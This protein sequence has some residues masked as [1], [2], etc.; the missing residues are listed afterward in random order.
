[1]RG[2]TME[3]KSVA[4]F[5][6][7][8][9]VGKSTISAELSGSL[10]EI[11]SNYK[12]KFNIES[13]V[14]L[15]AVDD[16]LDSLSFV[17]TDINTIGSGL[18]EYLL[19]PSESATTNFIVSDVKPLLDVSHIQSLMGTNA[20]LSELIEKIK[21]TGSDYNAAF[22]TVQEHILSRLDSLKNQ[23]DE[24][25][26]DMPPGNSTL[27][28]MLLAWVNEIMIVTTTETPSVRNSSKVFATLRDN[29]IS[30]DKIKY[31]VINKH[32]N[33][34]DTRSVLDILI[35]TYS[36]MNI[37]IFGPIPETVKISR[38][39]KYGKNIKELDIVTH[40]TYIWP[41]CQEVISR[42]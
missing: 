20:S 31:L 38:P 24:I 33:N 15:I 34:N 7:K 19:A 29:N 26:L 2:V 28:L 35:N 21:K 14:L 17:G 18:E 37:K 3:C 10:A 22:Q 25:I 27:S 39:H 42:A 36:S 13:R 8:G 1:M 12:E 41:I 16:Q 9:G 5:N 6:Q 40:Q 23:Y 11:R 30:Q 32:R 4:V